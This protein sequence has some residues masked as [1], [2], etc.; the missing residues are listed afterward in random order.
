MWPRLASRGIVRRSCKQAKPHQLQCGRGSRAAESA[1]FGSIQLSTVC[2]LQIERLRAGNQVAA[3]RAVDVLPISLYQQDFEPASDSAS[4]LSTAPLAWEFCTPLNQ[5]CA[6][7]S[8]SGSRTLR[9]TG[10]AHRS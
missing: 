6:S 8:G 4:R 9:L 7:T 3:S 10:A 2:V 5:K 1:P